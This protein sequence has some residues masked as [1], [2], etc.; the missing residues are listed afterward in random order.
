M[1]RS[2]TPAT[3]VLIA[4]ISAFLPAIATAQPVI[5]MNRDFVIN[6]TNPC[7]AG[8]LVVGTGRQT[9][10]LYE[11][12]DGSGGFHITAR[13]VTKGQASA[14][15]GPFDQPKT[16][17]L[18]SEYIAEQNS[19]SDLTSTEFTLVLNHVLIRK[20]ETEGDPDP[21]LASGTGD[22]FMWKETIHFTLKGTEPKSDAVNV[23][24]RCM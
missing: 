9:I 18:S 1:S 6:E 11:R 22:D 15:V 16:Y 19:S 5:V 21:L 17:V 24:V 8:E 10:A 7:I 14:V 20:S 12:P 3:V 4:I 13:T 2:G 23:H